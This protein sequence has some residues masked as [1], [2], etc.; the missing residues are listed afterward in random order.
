MGLDWDKK[1]IK[2]IFGEHAHIDIP[3]YQ[4]DYSWEESEVLDFYIDLKMFIASKEEK[5][6][7]GQ[8]IMHKE[9][10]I[11]HIVDGQQ[12]LC[13]S[14]IF[15]K[16][17]QDKA[18]K[19][20]LFKNDKKLNNLI[21]D[22][23]RDLAEQDS[24]GTY[25]QFRF[26]TTDSDKIF[27]NEY[28]YNSNH[29]FSPERFASR[30][31][32]KK[33]YELLS[34][35]IDEELK[36]KE[37]DD[38]IKILMRLRKRFV[39]GFF[40]SYVECDDLGQAYVVFETLNARGKQL[41][42]RD[43]LK[44][45]FFAHIDDSTVA[46]Q[47]WKEMADSFNKIKGKKDHFS[48]YIRAYWNSSHNFVRTKSLY[49]SINGL[50]R[51]IPEQENE[52]A[53]EFLKE[54]YENYQLYIAIVQSKPY[55]K[56]SQKSADL[57][58][59]IQE[60]GASS[61][62]PLILA[63]CKNSLVTVKDLELVLTAL[64]SLIIR[65]QVIMGYVANSNEIE[66]ANIA[67][68]I[69]ESNDKQLIKMVVKKLVE[70]TVVDSEITDKF[71]TYSPK[72]DSAKFLLRVLYDHESGETQVSRDNRK[73][74]L[75]HIMP[76]T[77]GEW[78]I[79]ENTHKIYRGRF[80]NMTLLNGSRNEKIQNTTFDKKKEVYAKSSYKDTQTISLLNNWST[81]EIDDRQKDLRDRILTQWPLIKVS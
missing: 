58:Y 51:S 26:N 73:V 79:E 31:R 75:E 5:Y 72:E 36:E 48:N 55:E 35:K 14:V 77:K 50:I 81:D 78:N 21:S 39:D 2:D 80:G 67:V 47:M 65:N 27:F 41:S 42:P 9:N 46:Q 23:E 62:Y 19:L 60:T 66:F 10:D 24:D 30:K 43:L 49:H 34:N 40:V 38:Q 4:R 53:Y 32:I 1:S 16:A 76:I 12:R 25:N 44:N 52:R 59:E 70:L 20:Q 45:Y 33:A 61:F 28:I 64:E 56:I 71:K 3:S 6:L 29:D 8:V 69:S 13:T 54:L 18:E 11:I 15:L 74:H 22:L 37:I 68:I 17:I 63:L 7:F 57:L